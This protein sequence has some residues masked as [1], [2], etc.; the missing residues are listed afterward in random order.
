MPDTQ[1]N[2]WIESSFSPASYDESDLQVELVL[3]DADVVGG[4]SIPVIYRAG[5]PDVTEFYNGLVEYITITTIS[6]TIQIPVEYFD[7]ENIPTFSGIAPTFIFYSTG[8]TVI[9]GT[10][11]LNTVY[12]TGFTAIPGAVD[13]T[14][15]FVVGNDYPEN[16]NSYVSVWLFPQS[17]GAISFITNYTN[18]SGNLT[19]SGTPIPFYTL[20]R[21]YISVYSTG[22]LQDIGW[23][24]KIVDISFAGW[25]GFGFNTD[26]YSTLSGLGLY[27]SFDVVTISGGMFLQ[28]TD[29]CSTAIIISDI[30]TDVFCSLLD[31]I[32]AVFDVDLG[33]GRVGYELLDV[34]SSAENSKG[35]NCDIE[36]LSLKITNFSLAEGQYTEAYNSITVDILDDVC[37]VSVSGTYFKINDVQVSGTLIP[38]VDG[39][40]LVYDPVDDFESLNGPTTFTVH[41]ENECGKIIEQSFNLTFGYIVGYENSESVGIDYGFNNRVVVRVTAENMASCPN[42]SSTAYV[43]E[44]CEL[45]SRDLGVSITGVFYADDY[46]NMPASIYPQSTAYFYDKEFRV[47]VYAKDFAGNSMTPF[48]IA[49]KI[50]DKPAN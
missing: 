26:I 32:V 15:T 18:F 39:Y 47:I 20:G 40:R 5:Q 14:I 43:L 49:Y 10:Q 19:T 7:C 13:K 35:I 2:I 21:D 42:L 31:Y 27:S 12:Q 4:Y 48:E 22:P 36:L 8:N 6:N 34:F 24:S 30:G 38:V 41:A 50:E 9:S 17:S 1:N 3:A 23:L 45:K 44:S 16:Y 37:P 46:R 11:S 33:T 25:V 29:I 28:S